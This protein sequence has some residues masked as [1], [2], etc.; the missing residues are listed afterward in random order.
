MSF[1]L[2]AAEEEDE[3]GDSETDRVDQQLMIWWA[4]ETHDYFF[5]CLIYLWLYVYYWNIWTDGAEYL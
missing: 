5:S 1:Y 2:H 4:A 3:G